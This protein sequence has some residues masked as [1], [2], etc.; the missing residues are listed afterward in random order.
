[1]KIGILGGGQLGRMLALAGYPLGFQFRLLDPSP[2]ACGGQVA[3]LISG[4]LNDEALLDRFAAGLDAVTVEWENIAV[5]S[6]KYLAQRLPFWPPPA[7]VEVS[8]D[9]LSEKTLFNRLGIETAPYAAVDM[10]ADL[11]AAVE[12]IG[13]PAIL[14]TRRMGYDGL[15]QWRLQTQDDVAKAAAELDAP[16]ILEGFVAFERE[17]SVIAVRGQDGAAAFY[18]LAENSHRDGILRLSYA[19]SPDVTALQRRRA[20]ELAW[21]V[22]EEL[23]YVG[24]LAIELFE[25]G[26]RLLANEMAPR[27][28]NSGHWSIDGAVTSQFENHVRA[29]A[30]LP[31]GSTDAV[32]FSAMINLIGD[33]PPVETLASIPGAHVHLYGK[34]ARAGRKLGHVNLRDDNPLALRSRTEAALAALNIS[35]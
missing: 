33:H 30:G 19:P 32:G 23:N 24:V 18:P 8:Q 16:A 7:A 11:A 21:A 6:A 17:L 34:S 12:K 22:L 10:P 5:P 31:L 25:V 13:L 20:E 14:K 35:L 1:M 15:G 28:H 2:Q 9:R 4:D 26:N 27:V 3:E 29:V